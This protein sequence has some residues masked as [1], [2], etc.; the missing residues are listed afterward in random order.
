MQNSIQYISTHKQLK[1]MA[2]HKC[3]VQ[4]LT[5]VSMPRKT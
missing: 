3:I 4:S 1:N 5:V 2:P